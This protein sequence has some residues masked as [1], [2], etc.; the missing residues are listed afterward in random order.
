MTVQPAEPARR[1]RWTPD[2]IRL[3]MANYT[4]EDV[5]ALPDDAPRVELRDLC[6]PIQDIT[7]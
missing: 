6:L 4:I 2:P 5:L 3:R 1:E 7:P